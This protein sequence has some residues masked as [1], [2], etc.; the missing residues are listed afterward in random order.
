MH[1]ILEESRMM[2]DPQTILINNLIQLVV[3]FGSW[4]REKGKEEILL[5]D[6]ACRTLKE[7]LRAKEIALSDGIREYESKEEKS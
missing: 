5:Y 2:V 7:T 1:S 3:N 6:Q 4:E